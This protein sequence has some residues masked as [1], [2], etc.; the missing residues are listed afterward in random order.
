MA[1]THLVK[2]EVIVRVSQQPTQDPDSSIESEESRITID[3]GRAPANV[4][5]YILDQIAAVPSP[6]GGPFYKGP[7]TDCGNPD[8][9]TCEKHVEMGLANGAN[10]MG[11]V[12]AGSRS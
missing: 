2:L 6:A 8:Y 3:T 4:V 1:A 12:T 7:K 9:D 11:L 5:Q 10:E